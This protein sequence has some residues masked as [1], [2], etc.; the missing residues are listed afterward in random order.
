MT[1]FA[2]SIRGWRREIGYSPFD[3]FILQLQ[4]LALWLEVAVWL[5][6]VS[7]MWLGA[8]MSAVTEQTEPEVLQSHNA[9]VNDDISPWQRKGKSP[10][11]QFTDRVTEGG[12][13]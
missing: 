4:L 6:L 12:Q 8:W 11:Q 7:A 1:L 5:L 3:I 9:S 2:A 10:L 13:E